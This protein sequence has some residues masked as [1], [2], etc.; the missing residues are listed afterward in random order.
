MGAVVTA[1]LL[2]AAYRA[3]AARAAA[4]VP[5]LRLAAALADAD[6]DAHRLACFLA[7]LGH[8]SGRLRFTRELWG[9]TPAQRRY[10][11]STKLS[12]ALGNVRPGDGARYMGRGLIQVTGRANAWHM[13]LQLRELLGE[14]VPD[15]VAAPGLMES[16]LWASLTA[17]AFWRSRGL[18]RYADARDF[19][20]Q[21]KRINGGINGLADRQALY[22]VALGALMRG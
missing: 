1:G 18:N 12:R 21:T 15:F 3:P 16:P 13:T 9:P 4:W 20:G 5:H 7:Q 8:E 22:S 19:V 2:V 17:A 11:P 14:S 6:A 10:E